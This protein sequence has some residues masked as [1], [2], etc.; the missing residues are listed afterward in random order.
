MIWFLLYGVLQ[1]VLLV[2]QA[3]TFVGGG[4]TNDVEGLAETIDDAGAIS[5]I[6]GLGIFFAGI[7]WM[8][9]VRRL[10]DRHVALTDEA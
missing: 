3:N 10:T 9:L 2:V 5:I 6:S 7:A 4:F 8:V 1:T